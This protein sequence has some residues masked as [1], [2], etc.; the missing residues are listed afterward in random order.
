MFTN[1]RTS[2]RNKKF[3]ILSR[4]EPKCSIENFEYWSYCQYSIYLTGERIWGPF[5]LSVLKQELHA[6]WADEVQSCRSKPLTTKCVEF[7]ACGTSEITPRVFWPTKTV[8]VQF[9]QL[10]CWFYITLKPSA[11]CRASAFQ[12]L[13]WFVPYGEL[14]SRLIP[15]EFQALKS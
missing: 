1:R 7:L 14:I 6:E 10:W 5:R 2:E 15:N 11:I 3:S 4:G 13:N 9:F 8:C 12:L